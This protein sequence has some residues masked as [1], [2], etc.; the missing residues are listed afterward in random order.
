MKKQ[1]KYITIFLLMFLIMG[2]NSIYAETAAGSQPGITNGTY[3]D[4]TKK[5]EKDAKKNASDHDFSL[6][7]FGDSDKTLECYYKGVSEEMGSIVKIGAKKNT[8]YATARVAYGKKI[9]KGLKIKNITGDYNIPGSGTR[10]GLII[11][12]VKNY[13]SET[14]PV[15]LTIADNSDEDVFLLDTE[16]QANTMVKYYKNIKVNAYSLKNISK[17]EYASNLTTKKLY[18][19]LEASNCRELL[20]DSL[21]QFINHYYKIVYIIV[22]FLVL[23]LGMVD[24]GKAVLSSKEDEMRQAQKRFIKRVA[25]GV[26][27]F[28]LP[29]IINIIFYVFN[30]AKDPSSV[31]NY[32]NY[33][34]GDS[35][36]DLD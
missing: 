3:I 20:G 25:M 34:N 18:N 28:I 35:C 14:C 6:N 12:Q 1:L 22:P 11:S 16:T 7:T 36:L 8:M 33:I 15:Y 17:E 13:N 19:R 2:F 27:V 30:F 9:V 26:V 21:L 29:T 10:T 31:D 32:F 5:A 4:E 24:F 23:V